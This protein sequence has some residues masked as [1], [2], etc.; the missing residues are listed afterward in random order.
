[1]WE[2]NT[3]ATLQQNKSCTHTLAPPD[4]V[5]PNYW[6]AIQFRATLDRLHSLQGPSQPHTSTSTDKQFLPRVVHSLRHLTCNLA[7]RFRGRL[8]VHYYGPRFS[9]FAHNGHIFRWRSRNY[10]TT[11]TIHFNIIHIFPTLFIDK[12]Q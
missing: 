2:I 7:V 11:N 9:F 5:K 12:A 10:K 4:I 6:L 1:M 3:P 8:P